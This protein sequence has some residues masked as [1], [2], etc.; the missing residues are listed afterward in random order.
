MP[1]EYRA[2]IEAALLF[3]ETDRGRIDVRGDDAAVFLHRILASDVRGLAV[4]R[5]QRSLLLSSKG[6]VLFDFDL[7]RTAEGATLSLPAGLAPALLSALDTYLFAESVKLED[8]SA[9]YAP[10]ALCGPLAADVVRSATGLEVPAEDHG[11][12]RGRS[13]DLDLCVARVSVAGSPGCLVDAGAAAAPTLWTR[14][15][16]AGARP[17]GLVVR[18]IL[19]VEAGQALYGEDLDENVYPQEAR[20]EDAFSLTKGCFIGQEVVAKIDTYGGLN[21]RLVGLK[22]SHDDP[23]ARGTRLFRDEDGERRDLGLITSWAYS[24]ALDTGLALGFVKRRH[25]KPG[26]R[27]HVGDSAAIAEIVSIPVRSGAVP[28]T[29]EFE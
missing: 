5:G 17:A 24:F 1:G 4:G 25:Q 2:G 21:K 22:I 15:R 3:D 12:I 6:K 28:I 27:F 14:M 8:T 16:E 23:V 18:D 13:G 11:W 19:R 26:T 29:G 7:F 9:G 20:L 10:L